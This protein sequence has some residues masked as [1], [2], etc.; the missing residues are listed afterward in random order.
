MV[1]VSYAG[2]DQKQLYNLNSDLNLKHL[3]DSQTCRCGFIREDADHYFFSCP[4]YTNERVTLFNEIRNYLSI[5]TENLLFRNDS[6]I[7]QENTNIFIVVQTYVKNTGRFADSN[8]YES[9][10]IC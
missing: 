8:F 9:Y 3:C 6:L 2:K 4:N 10:E 7:D 1:L 5:Y